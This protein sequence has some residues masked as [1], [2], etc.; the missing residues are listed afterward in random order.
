MRLPTFLFIGADRC[1]SKW[2]HRVLRQHPD[3]FV[4]VIADPYFF[5][6]EYDRGLE[7]YADLF[8]AAPKSVRAIGELSHDYIHSAEAAE[9]IRR[10]LPDVKLIATLRHPAERSFSSYSGAKAAGVM[11]ESFEDALNSHAFLMHGSRYYSNVRPY[12]ERFPSSQ[13]KLMLY[14]DL[15][16]DPLGYA[17]EIFDFI[18]VPFAPHIDYHEVFNP[19]SKPIGGLGGALSKRTANALR[20]LGLVKVLGWGK[21][22]AAIRK[23]FYRR[24]RAEERPRMSD[25]TRARLAG[26]FAPE[27]DNLEKL[28]GRDLS[29]WRI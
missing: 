25:A 20:K 2:L 26:V 29:A 24:L 28:T 5:D 18:G 15:V 13:I 12:L 17:A 3:V 8:S 6:R 7:W 11:S 14:D 21:S 27:I 1:G 16:A 19:L 10:H 23:I 22:N 9:R 4:P